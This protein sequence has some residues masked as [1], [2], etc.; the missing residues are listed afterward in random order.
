MF[1]AAHEKI[2]I[3]LRPFIH[4]NNREFLSGLGKTIWLHKEKWFMDI[5]FMLVKSKWSDTAVKL[6]L[7]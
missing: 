4:F 6:K 7:L 3:L 1:D 2:S 5:R